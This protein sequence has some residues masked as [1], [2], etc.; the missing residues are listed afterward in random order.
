M[1]SFTLGLLGLASLCQAAQSTTKYS[2]TTMFIPPAYTG[3][4]TNI[5]ASMITEDPTKT[6]YKLACQSDVAASSY[7]CKNDFDGVTY[8]DWGA[9]VDVTLN[10]TS[11]GCALFSD[12]AGVTSQ[13]GSATAE[14]RTL[15]SSESSLWMTAVTI[16]DLKKRKTT[17]PHA[18]QTSSN[19]I[20]K[21][22]VRDHDNGGGDGGS[23]SSGSTGS[24]A[25]DDGDSG[26]Q[27]NKKPNNNNDDCSTASILSL[28]WAV[29][30]MGLGGYLGLNLA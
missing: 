3:S 19:K 8:T 23:S 13:T 17:A 16:V 29:V 11:Y 26:S 12:R 28:S 30:A 20:C 15:S 14:S 10:S 25:D 9:R 2:T 1:K 18:T 21:R 6:L 5:Y 22:K 24:G 27:I 7:L 4:A